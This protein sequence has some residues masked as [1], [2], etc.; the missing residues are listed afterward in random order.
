MAGELHDFLAR[1]HERL[2]ELLRRCV[3]RDGTIDREPYERFREGLLRHIAIEERILFPLARHSERSEESGGGPARRGTAQTPRFL[4]TLGMTVQQLHRDHAAL[5]AL[6]V[7]PPTPAEIERIIEILQPHNELEEVA[8]G[9]YEAVEAI[10]GADISALMT[11]VRATPPVA[12]APHADTEVTRR[13]IEQL[14]REAEDG[15]R[16]LLGN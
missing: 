4:A 7:P 2:D 3:K 1:D 14:V 11:R 8:D 9:L 6:L 13:S 12:L 5:A 10:A 15:R 16:A